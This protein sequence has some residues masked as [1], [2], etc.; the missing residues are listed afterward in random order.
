MH[1]S[2]PIV[3]FDSAVVDK[4]LEFRPLDIGDAMVRNLEVVEPVSHRLTGARVLD[5]TGGE[6]DEL[7]AF[8][9]QSGHSGNRAWLGLPHPITRQDVIGVHQGIIESQW[10]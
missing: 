7:V 3:E 10:R 9:G 2:R 6:D 5:V 1:N 4:D 8:S